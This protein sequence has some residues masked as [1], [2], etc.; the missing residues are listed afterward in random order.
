MLAIM[1]LKTQFSG[2]RPEKRSESEDLP[3]V[4]ETKLSGQELAFPYFI[5][6]YQHYP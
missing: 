6:V 1:S 5:K 2:R 4:S 3:P